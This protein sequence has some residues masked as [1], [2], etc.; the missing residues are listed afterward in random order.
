MIDNHIPVQFSDKRRRFIDRLTR[1]VVTAC[2]IGILLVMMLLF[3]WL[4]WVV[5]PLFSSPSL[6]S[7]STFSLWQPKPAV[8][9]GLN[10]NWGWRIDQQGLARFIPLSGEPAE[11]ALQ[12][13]KGPV[14]VALTADKS[15]VLLLQSDDSVKLASADF[16]ARDGEP[17]WKFPL[18]DIAQ[19]IA[20]QRLQHPAVARSGD[21]Q[22]LAAASTGDAIVLAQLRAGQPPVVRT[23]N[24]AGSDQLLLTPDGKLLFAL[25]GNLLRVWRISGDQISLRDIITLQ[26]KPQQM[27][28]LSGGNSLLIAGPSG[29]AQWFDIASASGPHLN[30]IRYF[31]GASAQSLLLTE[32]QRR[33]F[34]TLNPRGEL[35]L[36][37]SKQ[38]GAIFSQ[39]LVAGIRHAEFAPEGD[40]LLVER[41]G[42]WQYYRL[43]NPWPDFSWR[44]LWQKV[45]YENYPEP[46]WVWQSTAADDHYQAKFSLMPMVS[47]TL[48]A[49]ALALLFATPLALAA[50]IY[51]AWFMSPALRRWIKP[52]IEMMGAL[53]SVVVG[54]I[55]GLWLA[56]RVTDHLLGVLLL[57]FMLALALLLCA[58]GSRRLPAR[59]RQRLCSDG[60]EVWL[61]LP[62]LLLVSML[63]LWLWPLLDSALFGRGLADRLTHGYEQRNL[64]V[65]GVAMGFALV[66]LIFTLAEDA[67]FSVPASLGQGSLA[68]G[69]TPWQTLSRVVLPSASAGIFAALMIGFGR[70]VGETMIVL[71]ATG[72]TPVPDGGLFDG[73]RTL[74]A[75]I[76]V[77]MP[78]A[79]AGS[80][81]YRILFLSALV[82]LVFTLVVNTL[83][84][85]V[86]QRLRLRFGKHEG[87]G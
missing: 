2:G 7:V 36:F 70:A 80:A 22:W 66:P 20:S 14:Q 64:L 68:L 16:T 57:P 8:A 34:A 75:N 39:K 60:R 11:P 87:Q 50:A 81:H 38:D 1:R 79:A 54:L 74:S 71:M 73:L 18:G 55:A 62:L 76:A 61:L 6:Q 69:A 30:F 86:R 56:P 17:R 4:I 83:A 35:Q 82:L 63:S 12:L 44:S 27:Q 31:H 48:K 52:G 85:L 25:A 37:A 5:T 19:K 33:V 77:E 13:A 72:N 42:Q 24:S 58:W 67:I 32:P 40:G 28:L 45:W 47:G 15:A 84:E 49:S 29:I 9:L 26:E 51:S 78:E 21:D 43:H 10:G 3:F 41:S 53:P 65:A 46:A 23:I 59:W